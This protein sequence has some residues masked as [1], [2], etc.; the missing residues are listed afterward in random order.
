MNTVAPLTKTLTKVA[1]ART[2]AVSKW[3]NRF[4][5]V[6]RIEKKKLQ[7]A[8]QEKFETITDIEQTNKFQLKIILDWVLSTDR[9]LAAD[10]ASSQRR[11]MGF[12]ILNTIES[13][14]LTVQVAVDQY[15]HLYPWQ[16]QFATTKMP[17]IFPDRNQCYPWKN[18]ESPNP[19]KAKQHCQNLS[20]ARIIGRRFP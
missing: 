20:W 5:F 9:E 10:L 12:I 14:I 15:L 18:S 11:S 8:R 17:P 16:T 3:V 13:I 19:T 6:G 1:T 7:S 2:R 4:L